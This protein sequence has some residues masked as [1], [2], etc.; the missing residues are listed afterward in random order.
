MP[1]LYQSTGV[2][3][4]KFFSLANALLLCGSAYLKKYQ[5]LPAHCGIVSVS[6]LADPPH[7]GHLTLTQ[8]SNLASG[9]SPSPLA[10]NSFISGNSRG[11]FSSATQPGFNNSPSLKSCFCAGWPASRVFVFLCF[12]VLAQFSQKIS[13]ICS[14]QYRWRENTQSRSL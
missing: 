9:D 12:C 13:G 2:Q 4:F 11:K 6:R 10:W 5:E 1:P 3:Y 8:F 14:P 7:L